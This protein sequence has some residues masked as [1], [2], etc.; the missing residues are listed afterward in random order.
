MRNGPGVCNARYDQL[1]AAHHA[2]LVGHHP[3]LRLASQ[4]A[5]ANH[6]VRYAV[7]KG[8]CTTQRSTPSLC[9]WY[10]Y[11]RSSTSASFFLLLPP[12]PSHNPYR[13]HLT[14]V[15]QSTSPIQLIQLS[16][17]ALLRRLIQTV[18]NASQSCREEAQHW[19]KG[20]SW[21]GPR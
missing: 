16:H 6:T 9:G 21:Q 18:Q 8:R 12:S 3:R 20:P 4:S 15:V 17:L 1:Y 13:T 10:K 11:G 19:R 2:F 14:Q 7:C 5:L